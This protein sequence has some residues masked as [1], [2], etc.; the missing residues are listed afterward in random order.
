MAFPIVRENFKLS[1]NRFLLT[2]GHVAE[3]GDLE[4][5]LHW[6]TPPVVEPLPNECRDGLAHHIVSSC[7]ASPLTE[8]QKT[9]I[10]KLPIFKQLKPVET[11]QGPTLT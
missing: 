4:A 6:I 8:K 1:G 9:L 5:L 11:D 10:L 7:K 2:K 3:P